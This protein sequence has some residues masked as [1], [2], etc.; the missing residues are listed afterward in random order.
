MATP[1]IVR[2]CCCE[3]TQMGEHTKVNVTEEEMCWG[4]AKALVKDASQTLSISEAPLH[5][6]LKHYIIWNAL[7]LFQELFLVI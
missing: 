7:Q 1:A 6:I 5:E 2:A 4:C 3:Q